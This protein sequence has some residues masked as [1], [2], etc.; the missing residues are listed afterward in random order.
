MR[1]TSPQRNRAV[2]DV[3]N[4]KLEG[5]RDWI[6]AGGVSGDGASLRFIRFGIIAQSGG[7]FANA[8]L[9]DALEAMISYRENQRAAAA[10]GPTTDN[11]TRQSTEFG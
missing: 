2:A 4:R 10:V 6:Y 9:I 11:R 5:E 8:E 3:L 1:P 7:A